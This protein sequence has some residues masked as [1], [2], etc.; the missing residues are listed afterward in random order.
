MEGERRR[1]GAIIPARGAGVEGRGRGGHGEVKVR[2]LGSA[3][4]P[5][6]RARKRCHVN[7]LVRDQ[8]A[9]RREWGVVDQ[10]EGLMKRERRD[11]RKANREKQQRRRSAPFLRRGGFR[12]KHL[13]AERHEKSHF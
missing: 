5:A 13:T 9:R 1:G 12:G 4:E 10:E 11:R 2:D 8:T 6:V 7:V 3:N